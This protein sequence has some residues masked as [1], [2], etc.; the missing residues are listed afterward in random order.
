MKPQF[1][2]AAPCSN[3]GKTTLTLGLLRLF[4]N[5]GHRVQPFK[6]GPDYIDPKHHT[7]AA[8]TPSINLDTFMM[9][10][11]HVESLYARY[12]KAADIAIVEGVMGLFDGADKMQGSSAEIAIL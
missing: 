8:G 2:I 11:A 1:L 7:L 10:T 12:S 4:K 3:S 9:S 6:C 5:K